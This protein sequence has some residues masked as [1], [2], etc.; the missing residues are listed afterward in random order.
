MANEMAIVP[1]GSVQIEPDNPIAIP[2]FDLLD[3]TDMA[4]PYIRLVQPTSTDI[5]LM[6]GSDARAGN[7]YNVALMEEYPE[8]V[9]SI[10]SVGKFEVQWQ[11]DG[12]P[13]MVYMVLGADEDLEPFVLKVSGTSVFNLKQLITSMV[14]TGIEKS[15]EWVVRAVSEKREGKTDDGTPTKWY[16]MKFYLVG[17]SEGTVLE[18]LDE[19]SVKHTPQTALP[20]LDVEVVDE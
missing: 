14:K 10:L 2:G 16:Q 17:R 15:W 20:D 3:T 19:L 12:E 7:F 18:A 13:Q 1:V 9:F 5:E 6:D 11:E 8:L 4:V